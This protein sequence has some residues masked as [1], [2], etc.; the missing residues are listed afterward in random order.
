MK[1]YI[2]KLHYIQNHVFTQYLTQFPIPM[3]L[4]TTTKTTTTNYQRKKLCIKYIS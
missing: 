2:G 1:E 3:A 4:V